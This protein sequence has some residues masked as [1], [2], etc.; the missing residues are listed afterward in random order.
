MWSQ[1]LSSRNY[2]CAHRQVALLDCRILI[3][4]EW[5]KISGLVVISD[6]IRPRFQIMSDTLVI[7]RTII[8][9]RDGHHFHPD[10]FSAN[11]YIC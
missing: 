11:S 9:V 2:A 5:T 7:E 1:I 4:V 10:F 8:E 6:D 3:L